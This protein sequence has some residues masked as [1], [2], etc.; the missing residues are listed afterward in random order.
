MQP[1]F[2]DQ[3][4][5]CSDELTTQPD[6]RNPAP[7]STSKEPKLGRWFVGEATEKRFF[8]KVELNG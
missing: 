6:R 7:K 4:V 3:A 2:A 5:L 1:R 8:T